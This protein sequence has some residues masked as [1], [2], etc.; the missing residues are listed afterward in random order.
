MRRIMVLTLVFIAGCAGQPSSPPQAAVPTTYINAS[1]APIEQV[2]VS[3]PKGDVDTKR[4]KEAKKAGFT[5]I[6]QDGTPLFCRSEPHIGSRIQKDTTCLTREQWDDIT[7]QTQ[8][9]LQEWLR[10]NPPPGGDVAPP[11]HNAH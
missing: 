5:V 9:G 7:S 10:S 6:N 3:S 11:A 1:G 4:L 2:S 8:R